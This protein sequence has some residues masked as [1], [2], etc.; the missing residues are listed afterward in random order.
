M[1]DSNI[2]GEAGGHDPVDLAS[3]ALERLDAFIGEWT[4]DARF[5]GAPPG[6]PQGRTV[7]EWLAD[8]RFLVQRWEVPH[9]AAPDGIAI[10]GFDHDP[11]A[12]RQHYFDS[13][14]VA[15]VYS[16]TFDDG[17]W[18]LLR[19]KPDFSPLDFSQRFSAQFSAD[20]TTIR[21]AWETSS[22]GTHWTHDFELIYTRLNGE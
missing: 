7:F 13:R 9:P 11:D 14:G 17:A 5:P 1:T 2:S 10:I 20:G 12:Y 15:R 18:R 4:M 16:M 8:R 19:D 21:G 22:D 3:A 6:G